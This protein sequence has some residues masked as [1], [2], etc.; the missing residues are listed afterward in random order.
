MA[1]YHGE[2]FNMANDGYDDFHETVNFRCK[3]RIW[4]T[5]EHSWLKV[6]S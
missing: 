2:Y 5:L 6:D 1:K 3:I 4:N